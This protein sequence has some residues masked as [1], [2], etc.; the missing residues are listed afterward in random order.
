MHTTAQTMPATSV[1]TLVKQSFMCTFLDLSFSLSFIAFYHDSGE[2][3][4]PGLD[5][6]SFSLG[7]KPVQTLC[8][9]PKLIY[10]M[11]RY[12]GCNTDYNSVYTVY[13]QIVL[14]VEMGPNYKSHLHIPKLFECFSLELG[15]ADGSSGAAHL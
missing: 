13:T 4:L 14:S 8:R 10:S 7:I 3:P 11:V 15:P 1:K 5:R 6:D 12:P 2:R 9:L